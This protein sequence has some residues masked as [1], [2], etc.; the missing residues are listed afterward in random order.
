MIKYL[1]FLTLFIQTFYADTI[2]IDNN[3]K[4]DFY[5]SSEKI[6]FTKE[7]FSIKRFKNKPFIKKQKQIS[8]KLVII[9]GQNLH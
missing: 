5:K 4:K 1:I 9:F 7:N 8:L 3:F 2:V 6:F